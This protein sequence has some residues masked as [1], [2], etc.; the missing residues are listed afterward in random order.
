MIK[1]TFPKERALKDKDDMK[2]IIMFTRLDLDAVKRQA[3]QDDTLSILETIIAD[4]T[5]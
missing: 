2:A 4:I 1:A 5:H 3:R